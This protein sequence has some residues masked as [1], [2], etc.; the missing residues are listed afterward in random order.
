MTP[1]A[2]QGHFFLY[3][4]I[5]RNKTVQPP[6]GRSLYGVFWYLDTD[7]W[8]PNDLSHRECLM[9]IEYEGSLCIGLERVGWAASR[10]R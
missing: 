10:I 3:H 6:V 8:G 4:R 5:S 9:T 1:L 7:S 2:A